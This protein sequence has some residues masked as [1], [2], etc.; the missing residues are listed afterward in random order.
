MMLTEIPLSGLQLR[1]F[2]CAKFCFNSRKANNFKLEDLWRVELTP[3]GLCALIYAVIILTLTVPFLS[4]VSVK[5][6]D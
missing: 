5:P 2:S 4:F 6:V 1:E 3:Q